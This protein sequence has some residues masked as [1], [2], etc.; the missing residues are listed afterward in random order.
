[1]YIFHFRLLSNVG[2]SEGDKV[3]V[4]QLYNAFKFECLESGHEQNI[5]KRLF[6]EHL[7]SV[8]PNVHKERVNERKSESRSIVTYYK[9]L[10]FKPLHNLNQRDNQ[11]DFKDIKQFINAPFVL[12]KETENCLIYN[13]DTGIEVNGV[14][15]SK[16]LKF[17]KSMKW[18]LVVC[19][20]TVDVSK[21]FMDST[22]K[23]SKESVNVIC[24][25][26]LMLN[27]CEGVK[28]TGSFVV[29][30][31]HVVEQFK[32]RNNKTERKVRSVVCDHIVPMNSIIKT[33]RTC[34]K[35]A[36]ATQQKVGIKNVTEKTNV[37]T[38]S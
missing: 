21:V 11:S 20:K 28:V 9:G 3:E 2:V 32:D 37:C 4:N 38:M 24:A 5:G 18:D 29:S 17:Y 27:L 33:C 30:R 26:V 10:V 22:F 8:F 6:V 13:L 36:I 1:V 19:G 16:T 12:T 25:G 15:I 31:I 34:Q 7:V 35:M 23:F 14:N